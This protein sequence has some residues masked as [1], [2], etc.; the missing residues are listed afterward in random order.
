[1]K[2]PKTSITIAVMASALAAAG[3]GTASDHQH[4]SWCSA[5]RNV[6]PNRHM[7]HNLQ[8]DLY[9][10]RLGWA[11]PKQVTDAAKTMDAECGMRLATTDW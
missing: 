5:A 6:L 1:M 2:A 4:P 8:T 9:A 3:C 11:A 7:P 10:I